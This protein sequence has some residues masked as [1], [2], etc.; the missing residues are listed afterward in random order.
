MRR[1]SLL[2]RLLH[3]GVRNVVVYCVSTGVAAVLTLVL[4]RV[5]WRGLTADAFGIWALVDPI[6]LPTASL[7]LFGIDHAIVKQLRVDRLSLQAITGN[8]LLCTLP[9]TLACLAVVGI[10]AQF[11]IHLAWTAALLLT[12]AGEAVMQMLQTAFR[13]AGAV[14]L[15]ATVLLSRNLL[16]M[17]VLLLL[18]A[19]AEPIPLSLA[20]VFLGRGASVVLVSLVAFATLRPRPALDWT[21]YIDAVRYGFPL[22]ITTVIFA[23]ADMTDRWFLA[24][25]SGVVA[26][27]IYALHLK[28]AAILSQ[29]IVI[30]FGLWFPPERFKQ[31][32]R[33]DGGRSFFVTTAA[34]LTLICGYLSGAVWLARDIVLPILA[35]GVGASPLVLACCL[36]GVFCLALSQAFNVGLLTP[37]HT[38]KNAVCTGLAAAA[39]FIAAAFLVP[40]WG[41]E[42]AGISRLLS[43]IVLLAVTAGW[44]RRVF[45]IAFPFALIL[46]YIILSVVAAELIDQTV[47]ARG[48]AGLLFAQGAWAG[49]TLVLA[50]LFRSSLCQADPAHPPIRIV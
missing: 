37:G 2:A 46:L 1:L 26:V 45:P 30:P 7:L 50:F 32:D 13:A 15:F 47:A 38:A 8:L 35:P 20:A 6:F 22:V 27:G 44:S 23:L 48:G 19:Y 17:A 18:R 11:G 42:G 3:P 33:P 36:G 31:M 14:T 40:W 16:Y 34:V 29:A 4:T 10:V 43:G 24:G 25:F 21:R 49:V 12:I 28:L 5:L 41:I 39:G 9:A